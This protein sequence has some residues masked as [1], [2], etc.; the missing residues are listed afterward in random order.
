MHAPLCGAPMR[1]AVLRCAARA[2]MHCAPEP[3]AFRI[4]HASGPTAGCAPRGIW[5]GL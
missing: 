2:R 5:A 1:T 4:T 3:A